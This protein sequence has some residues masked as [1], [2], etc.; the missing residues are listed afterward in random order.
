MSKFL[1]VRFYFSVREGGLVMIRSRVAKK[2]RSGSRS[3]FGQRKRAFR[4]E[5]E[6]LEDR[7]LPSTSLVSLVSINSVGTGAGNGVSNDMSLSAD[8]RYVAFASFATNLAAGVTETAGLS[9]VY[10]RDQVTGLTTLV[11]VSASPTVAG[12]ADSLNPV[13]TP[14]GRYV[15]FVSSASNLVSGLSDTNG[16]PDIFVRNLTAQTTVCVTINPAGH[17][18]NFSSDSPVISADG[19]YVAFRSD[20]N[21]LVSGDNNGHSDIFARDLQLHTTRLVSIT[22]NGTSGNADSI[23]PVMNGDGRFI[24]FQSDAS[25]L[26]AGDTNSATDVFFRDMESGVT[27]LVSISA[28]GSGAGNGFS[29]DPSISTDGRYIAF[30]SSATNLVTGVTDTNATNDVFVRDQALGTTTLVTVSSTGSST[31]NSFSNTPVIS[32]NGGFVAFWSYATNLV[33]GISDQNGG[34]DVFVRDLAHQTTTLVSVDSAGTG[35]GNNLSD[36][37]VISSDGRYVAFRS[38]ASNL[39]S[40]TTDTN[41]TDDVFV[42]DLQTRATK[43]LSIS[44][45]GVSSGNGPSNTPVISSSGNTV[46]FLSAATNLTSISDKN[47]GTDVFAATTAG[48]AAFGQTVTATE[49]SAFTKT[50]A[51]FT[52]SD[53]SAV[54]GNFS[55]TITWGDGSNSTGT[56]SSISS[57]GFLVT[58]SHTYLEEGSFSATVIISSLQSSATANSSAQVADAPLTVRG[59]V[60][61]PSGEGEVFSGVVASFTDADPRAAASDYSASISW[62]DGSQSAGTVTANGASFNVQGSHTY[63]EEGT[64]AV[65]VTISDAAASVIAHSTITVTDAPLTG[66]GITTTLA[67]GSTFSGT[68][69]SFTDADPSGIA[70]DFS[71]TIAWGDGT[72]TPGAITQPGGGGTP[73]QVSESHSGPVANSLVV[74]VTISDAGGS[75]TT[76]RS[77]LNV[78]HRDDILGRPEGTGQWWLGTSTGS[79][80]QN[81]LWA[82]WSSSVTWVDLMTGDFNGDGRADIAGRVLQTGQW[83]VGLSTGSSFATTLWTTWSP[84][85]VWTDVRVGDFNGDGKADIIGRVKESGQWWVSLSTGTGFQTSLWAT[86]SPAVT[87]SD[88]RIGD[89]NGDGKADV[90]G[91]VLQTG[92]WWASLSNGATALSTSLW[93]TWSPAVTWVD[94]RIGDL[95]GDGKADIIGRVLQSGQWWASLSNGSTALSTSLWATWSPA[96]T[97]VDVRI[98]D[99]NG[100]GNADI[101]GRVLQSGQ[102]WAGISNGSAF[103]NSLWATWSTAVTWVD[104]QVGDFNGDGKSDITGRV[105]Q[106]GQWWTGISNGSAF[107]TSLWTT[108]A[109]AV[110]WTG[111]RSGDFA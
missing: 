7:N 93:A 36:T 96:V 42:R 95:N 59:I 58:G 56:I 24:A 71:A 28:A 32:G 12:N 68:V 82:A 80:F 88:V 97:W 75:K 61:P 83:W 73:F 62:G 87:W 70:W 45:T 79:S 50:V 54:A 9:Q 84:N 100:D 6:G 72:S 23:D 108:W 52:Y 16:L 51:T 104:V 92:Q 34:G 39:V 90:I 17:T 18:G 63:S 40:G 41:G 74:I 103:T 77:N 60:N 67:A 66:T 10:V 110:T 46:A 15:A 44:T 49:G 99:L 31:G 38:D 47:G 48:I 26:V 13:I 64:P 11:S 19:R 76:A 37:P 8:G 107:T 1:I 4:L 109:T 69:A 29:Q 86:W 53:P 27:S 43:L 30:S 94:V 14:D 57:G 85:V 35:T 33:P 2:R 21:D 101:I 3:P 25:N 106:N 20:S 98:A 81:S 89:L 22:P 105:L 55:A 102:W 111:V 78:F 5:L 91:R 65:S